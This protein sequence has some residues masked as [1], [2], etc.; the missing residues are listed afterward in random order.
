VIVGIARLLFNE[1]RL[2]GDPHYAVS[3]ERKIDM[4]LSFLA[5]S[6]ALLMEKIMWSFS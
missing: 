1:V 3:I 5:L 4:W 2:E 6:I